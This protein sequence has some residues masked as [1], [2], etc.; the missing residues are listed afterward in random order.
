[1]ENKKP[2]NQTRLHKRWRGCLRLPSRRNRRSSKSFVYYCFIVELR[3][4][5]S[6][7]S[8]DHQLIQTEKQRICHKWVY[9]SSSMACAFINIKKEDFKIQFASFEVNLTT[10]HFPFRLLNT[11]HQTLAVKTKPQ[12][13]T[14]LKP[15][16]PATLTLL[17][18]CT[19]PISPQPSTQ[20]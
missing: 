5:Q 2:D 14:L 17:L 3:L 1:M 13:S 8:Q 6:T 20:S 15:K 4:K 10:D 7:L 18:V 11:Q 9:N 12:T 16:Y 19:N